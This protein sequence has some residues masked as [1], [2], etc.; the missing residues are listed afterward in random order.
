MEWGSYYAPAPWFRIKFHACCV[1]TYS[2]TDQAS[3]RARSPAD[4]SAD[5][6]DVTHKKKRKELIGR[7]K[8][9]PNKSTWVCMVCGK[10]RHVN[11]YV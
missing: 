11:M 7:E 2:P 5:A 1:C 10:D 8:S 6:A 3:K 9:D 4:S